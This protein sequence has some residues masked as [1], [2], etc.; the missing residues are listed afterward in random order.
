MMEHNIPIGHIRILK[1]F[2]YLVSPTLTS[3]LEIPLVQ[4]TIGCRH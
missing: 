2:L 1:D 3:M 4:L